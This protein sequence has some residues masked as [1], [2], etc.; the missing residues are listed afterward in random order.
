M[1][2]KASLAATNPYLQNP[3]KRAQMVR[4]SVIT[5]TKIEGVDFSKRRSPKLPLNG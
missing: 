1:A 4:T 5:S 2:K 3:K